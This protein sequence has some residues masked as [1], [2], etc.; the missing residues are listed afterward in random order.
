M[1]EI[2]MVYELYLNNVFV[3]KKKKQQYRSH[4]IGRMFTLPWIQKETPGYG[5]KSGQELLL[6]EAKRC[7]ESQIR[8]LYVELAL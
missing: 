4:L 6:R 7:L 5:I 1:S 8:N 2:F 3:K